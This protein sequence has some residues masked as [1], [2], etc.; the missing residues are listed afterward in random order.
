MCTICEINGFK[1]LRDD[2]NV[3]TEKV[4]TT[5]NLPDVITKCLTATVR[6]QLFTQ[7]DKL[8]NGLRNSYVRHL[9]G[10]IEAGALP[11]MNKYRTTA[12]G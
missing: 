10:T 5:L 2:G 12:G 1:E 11:W 3:V 4:C 7:L 6:T 9:G 8:V